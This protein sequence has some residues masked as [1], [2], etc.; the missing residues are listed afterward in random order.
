MY[1]DRDRKN[2]KLSLVDNDNEVLSMSYF[3]D[4]FIWIVNGS[5]P[6]EITHEV[7]EILYNNL[8]NLFN[9]EYEFNISNKLCNKSDS[10][11]VWLSDQAVDLS[12]EAETD[13]VTRLVIEKKDN[14]IIIYVINPFLNKMGIVRR[15][16]TVAF[17]PSGNGY[18]TKNVKTGL[19]F[20]D[21]I[22]NLFACTMDGVNVSEV[23]EPQKKLK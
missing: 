1:L 4:E 21:D 16:Y 17:S 22:V 8:S 2:S 13:R 20:Q 3:F 19:S 18:M 11:I 15:S 14:K 10:K 12:D 7:D 23:K 5:N 6:I 9:N